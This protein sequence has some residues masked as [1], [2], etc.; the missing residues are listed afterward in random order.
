MHLKTTE[1]KTEYVAI[2]IHAYTAKAYAH[3]HS[4]THTLT[5]AQDL[6]LRA[7]FLFYFREIL[8]IITH[9]GLRFGW[10]PY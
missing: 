6:S 3:T 4:R 1:Y 10:E 8:W 7:H 9:A 5:N 2:K